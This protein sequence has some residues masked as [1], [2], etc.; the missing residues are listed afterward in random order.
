MVFLLSNYTKLHFF[1]IC[2]LKSKTTIKMQ[3]REYQRG[4]IPMFHG[5]RSE[6]TEA[7]SYENVEVRFL[8]N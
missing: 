7:E 4:L 8:K 5:I 1:L 3:R 6:Y 2:V